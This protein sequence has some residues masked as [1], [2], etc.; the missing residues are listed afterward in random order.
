[1]TKRPWPLLKAAIKSVGEGAKLMA[2]LVA[3]SEQPIGIREHR[4]KITQDDIDSLK[5]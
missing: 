3:V 2:G 5:W 4:F 1:V